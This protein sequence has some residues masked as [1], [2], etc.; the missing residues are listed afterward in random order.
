MTA[1]EL[2]ALRDRLGMTQAAL[3]ARLGT[4]QGRV[5]DWERGTRPVPVQV[6]AHLRTIAELHD[7][8]DRNR[9]A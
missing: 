8:E 4:M 9:T 2:R 3:A 1:A 6:E 7:C 5:S